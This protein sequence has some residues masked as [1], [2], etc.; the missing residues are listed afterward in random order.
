MPREM[1][2]QTRHVSSFVVGDEG[3]YLQIRVP[4]DHRKNR[5]R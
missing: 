3:V 1:S 5:E 2:F 4:A